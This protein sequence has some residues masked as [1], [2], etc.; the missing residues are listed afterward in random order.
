ML[1]LYDYIYC[2]QA[3]LQPRRTALLP[4]CLP[5]IISINQVIHRFVCTKLKSYIDDISSIVMILLLIISV[6]F[7]S[8]FA[9]F[10]IYSETIAVAQLGG[11]LVNRTLTLR[12]DLVEMLPMDFQSMDNIIDN[13]YKY[14]RTTIEDY[15]DGIFNQ[16]D[17]TQAKK[18]KCQILSVWDRLIQSYMDR[19]NH[20]DALGPRVPADSIV[21]TIDEIV[22]NSG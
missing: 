19:N 13:A 5:G 15:V 22:N 16:T 3:W 21:S 12:P 20:P 18:L 6:V 8:L 10:Q 2:F 4:L 17:P 9:F 1:T 7:L 14:G 11:N